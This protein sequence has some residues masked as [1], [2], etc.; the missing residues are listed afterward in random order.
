M[1]T[2]T[3]GNEALALIR[4]RTSTRPE[5]ALILG[6]GLGQ[7][8]AE[9][10][11]VCTIDAGDIPHYPRSSVEGHSGKLIFGVVSD[12]ERRSRPLLVLQGRVHFYETA[13]LETILFPLE[14][15]SR[16]GVKTLIV[17]NAA[18]G[19]NK[20]FQPGDLMVIRDLLNLTGLSL[21]DFFR[22]KK[23]TRSVYF[24]KNLQLL[25]S[26]VAGKNGIA[27]K[28]GTYC[29][30]KGPTYETAAEIQMLK[31][32][33]A[34]AVGMSTVPE[35]VFSKSLGMKTLGISLISNLA[36]GI[37]PVPLS[38]TE[39]TETANRVKQRWTSLMKEFLLSL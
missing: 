11:D 21:T 6:S 38:H 16:L 19:I 27:L 14:L 36:T 2:K 18:G 5:I 29:W 9:V 25:F 13:N 1:R 4:S 35:I 22:K 23:Y 24:D 10:K 3:W 26:T 31:I 15:A 37:S 17:T 8:G 12:N 20:N 7:F 28:E 33:G 39:V 30:L 34:D 32:L